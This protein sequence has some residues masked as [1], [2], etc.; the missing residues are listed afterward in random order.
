M[1]KTMN[2]LSQIAQIVQNIEMFQ[3]ACGELENILTTLRRVSTPPL[4]SLSF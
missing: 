1:L 2:N 3:I 4:M